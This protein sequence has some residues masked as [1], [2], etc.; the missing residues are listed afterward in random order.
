[1][2]NGGKDLGQI[3]RSIRKMLMQARHLD[4]CSR[5]VNMKKVYKFIG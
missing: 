4:H 3:P 2:R 5:N 1:M